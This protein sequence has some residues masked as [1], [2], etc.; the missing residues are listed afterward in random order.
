LKVTLLSRVL[1]TALASDEIRGHKT[2]MAAAN[3]TFLFFETNFAVPCEASVCKVC[4]SDI[5]VIP[6]QKKGKTKTLEDDEEIFEDPLDR[7]L[8][9]GAVEDQAV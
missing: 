6:R 4:G 8:E 2:L 1:E 7:D 3:Q 5:P 9:L